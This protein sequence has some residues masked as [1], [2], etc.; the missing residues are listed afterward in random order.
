LSLPTK[1]HLKLKIVIFKDKLIEYGLYSREELNGLGYSV[2][3]TNVMEGR[4][5]NGKLDGNGLKMDIQMG[6]F[7]FL[8]QRKLFTENSKTE[9]SG[10]SILLLKTSNLQGSSSKITRDNNIFTVYNTRT[11]TSTKDQS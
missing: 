8:I 9:T 3:E 2:E 6:I 4:F 10:Q 7:Y 1:S 11:I 5:K